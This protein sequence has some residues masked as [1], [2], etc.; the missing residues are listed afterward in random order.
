MKGRLSEHPLAELIR[1]ISEAGL[2]GALRL[3]RER[4]RAALYFGAGP[5]V[6]ARS[7]LRPHRLPESLV[8]WG[9]IPAERLAG[10]NVEA[11]ADD[12]AGALLASANVV[13]RD[14]LPILRARQSE[15]VLRT[16]LLWADGEWAFDPRVRV[17]HEAPA[18]GLATAPL[19]IEAARRL[20]AEFVARRVAF[21]DATL[22]PG[23]PADLQLLPVEGFVLSRVDAPLTLR[24]LLAVSGLPDAEA[25]R[26]VYALTLGGLLL[27]QRWPRAF[28]EDDLA[29]ARHAAA[30]AASAP[31]APTQKQ[32]PPTVAPTQVVPDAK[33][34]APADDLRAEL[35][36][37]F[38]RAGAA[39]H[40]DVLGVSRSAS[41]ADIKRAY[42]ALAKRF[43]PDRFR[44][45]A[46]P[47]EHARADT[48][49]SKIAQA[50]DALKD[51]SLRAD[52]DLKLMKS[53]KAGARPAPSAT[54]KPSTT[55][56]ASP[57][58]APADPT[59]TPQYRA[60]ESFQQGLSA[61]QGGNRV[62]AA[63][64]FGDAAR[65]VPKQARYRA[66]Y[67]RALALDA[68]RRR[69]AE[70]EL[71]AAI[72]LD[73][74]NASYRVLLAHVY[75]EMGLRRRAE[76]ELQRALSIDPHHAEAR[77]ALDALDQT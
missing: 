43:H 20:P 73:E 4:A 5:L 63:I 50:Y 39:T 59:Q 45:E 67:G 66:Y 41:A 70:S 21:D 56:P 30:K 32:P 11:A 44:R 9:V 60:E 52:Y 55:P 12:E 57:P 6:S 71:K 38:A 34:D 24:E 23:P 64:H 75:R 10:L 26:A 15:D 19:L 47:G 48:A 17:E 46:T 65:L 40:Y 1:E 28:T 22:A 2:S 72:A 58:R 76:G 29:R 61:L 27:R 25:R 51:S 54:P 37:L 62:L 35:E 77:R 53:E 36:A 74:A 49:F 33:T 8:R 14:D 7:N 16:T 68:S 42:Y 18:A 3:A 31:A 69:E 13:S